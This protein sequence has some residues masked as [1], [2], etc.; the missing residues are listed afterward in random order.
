MKNIKACFFD[1]DGTL[2]RSDHTISATVIEAVQRLER[3]GVAPV[4]ATGRSYEALLPIK[5]LLDLHSPVICYNG[6][7]IVNG[8]DNSIMTH[9]TLPDKAAIEIIQAVRDMGY[10]IL[11]YR[12]GELIYERECYESKEYYNRIKM[13]GRII[14]FDNIKM[15]NLTKCLII[16]DHEKLVPLKE[17]IA[18]DYNN[19]VNVFFSD[20][21]F[22]EIVPA[23]IDKGKAVEEVMTLMGETV[24]QA[25]A[26]GDGFNDLPMLQAARWGV[27]MENALPELK[28][29]FPP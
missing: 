7:M 19:Q 2:V 24:D 23:G 1:L 16:A 29:L 18:R 17:K 20:P 25:M 6:A 9:H 15:L 13:A 14:N 27:V 10:H 12:N 3:E 11:G 8:K 22:L 28:K 4:I 5:A 26:M 21:R